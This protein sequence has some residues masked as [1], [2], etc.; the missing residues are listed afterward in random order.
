[1]VKPLTDVRAY[2]GLLFILS[3]RKSR[4]VAV[5]VIFNIRKE[6]LKDFGT[7]MSGLK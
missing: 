1:M 7:Q 5:F 4:A 6:D 3:T 2:C